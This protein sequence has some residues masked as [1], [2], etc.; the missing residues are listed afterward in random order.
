MPELPEVETI[1]RGL[2]KSI[3]QAQIEQVEVRFPTLRTPIPEN[4]ESVMEGAVITDITRRSKYMLWQ[5]DS[6]DVML[7][8]LGM[9]G[10]YNLYDAPPEAL[11]KHEHVLWY[12]A[13]GRLLA[14]E[15]PR[16]FGIIDLMKSEDMDAHPL[17]AHLGPEPLSQAFNVRYF[18]KALASRSQAIKPALMDA[19]LVVGVGNIYAAEA[20]FRAGI[21]PHMPAKDLVQHPEYIKRLVSA[22]KQVLRAAIDSGGSSL[23]DFWNPQGGGGYFQHQFAVYG[24]KGEDCI[25][26]KGAIQQSKQVGR[27]TFFCEN[28]QKTLR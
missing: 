10:R 20:C 28:C 2:L 18:T 23:R 13:D 19:K 27:S 14:Y 16:R 21:H 22:I 11:K 4:I 8:H 24:R 25:T 1:K 17:L 9:S 7:S 26:C 3:H 6:G 12:L 5:L 15:D